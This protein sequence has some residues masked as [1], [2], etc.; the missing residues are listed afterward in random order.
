M[1]KIF[2]TAFF[3]ILTVSNLF[4]EI[5]YTVV[6]TA[7]DTANNPVPYTMRDTIT[8]TLKVTNKNTG[9]DATLS[10][11]RVRFTFSNT[12]MLINTTGHTAPTGWTFTANTG[13][14]TI[15]FNSTGASY[16]I[17]TNNYK[18]FVVSLDVVASNV[19]SGREYMTSSVARYTNK[20]NSTLNPP[21]D[22]SWYRKGLKI[23]SMTATPDLLSPG[24]TFT[25]TITV[26]NVSTQTQTN[27]TADPNPP[28]EIQDNGFNPN[29]T[30]NPSIAS[31]GVLATSTYNYTTDPGFT[32][33]GSVYFKCSVRNGA[34]NTTSLPANSNT[35][36]I[37]SFIASISFTPECPLSGE[38]VNVTMTLTN[39][40]NFEL[41]NVTPYLSVYG[42]ATAVKLTGPIPAT[43]TLNKGQS[44]NI[45]YTY[46]ITGSYDASF[47]FSGYATGQKTTPPTGT[48][49]TPTYTTTTRYLREYSL[50][51]VPDTI[52]GGANNFFLKFSL[53]NKANTVC[54]I[55]T[56]YD[57]K[58]ISIT[59][60]SGFAYSV[61]NFSY[62]IGNT[63]TDTNNPD[64]EYY[65]SN[66]TVVDTS[67]PISFTSNNAT[68]NLPTGK[69]ATFSLFFDS[70]PKVSADT[71]YT[72]LTTVEN[73]KGSS[74]NFSG[75]NVQITVTKNPTG[76]TNKLSPTKGGVREKHE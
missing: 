24:D 39:N 42:T 57:V 40:N 21:P 55:D 49:Q 9:T 26:Q 41:S 67:N 34:N 43:T 31:L 76:I 66:W 54:P 35:V 50:D 73:V 32:G 6:N 8:M 12:T 70:A 11:N 25:L 75:S 44:V 58:K 59:V 38:T 71:I 61:G 7:A 17:T 62:L 1:K 27:I 4:A 10:I 51:L 48:R 52:I 53:Q 18:D 23:V 72:F 37:G 56:N 69:N 64:F 68:Y 47:Y 33:E 63:I 46:Q 3:L 19:D 29:T 13:K 2:L 45:T 16:N 22:V 30:S 36:Y 60:P 65:D 15:T 74:I 28:E 20:K 14:N 5:K